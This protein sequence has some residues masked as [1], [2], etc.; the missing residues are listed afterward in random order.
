M[1]AA[2]L[3][4]V[5]TPVGTASAQTDVEIAQRSKLIELS[6]HKAPAQEDVIDELRKEKLKIS[7]AGKFGVE[8]S[9]SEVDAAYTHMASR[10]RLTPEQLTQQLARSGVAV[11]TLKHRIR[12]DK[13]WEKYK[14]RQ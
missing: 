14:G 5:L 11:D 12:A 13:A 8:V 3:V 6:T 10:M 2:M 9:D 4:I 7:E 1:V